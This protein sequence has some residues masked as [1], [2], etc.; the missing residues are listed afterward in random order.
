MKTNFLKIGMPVLVFMVAIVFAFA[1]EKTTDKNESLI[2]GYIYKDGM[3]QQASKDCNNLS[4]N[5]C[6]TDEFEQV[7]RF[8]NPAGTMC[9]EPL[10]H[11]DWP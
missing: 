2:T 1:S 6:V 10:Y 7:Y 11:Q 5:M 9:S 3:C 8:S 4:G